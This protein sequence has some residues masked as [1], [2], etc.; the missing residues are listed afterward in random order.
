MQKSWS[1]KISAR[2]VS[3]LKVGDEVIIA[4][5]LWKLATVKIV[6]VDFIIADGMKF[7]RD[8]GFQTTGVG[9][10]GSKRR[11]LKATPERILLIKTDDMVSE[12]QDFHEWPYAT[13]EE[14]E[15]IFAIV[16]KVKKRSLQRR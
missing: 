16:E 10:G 11:L 8:T 6:T 4:G 3:D 9:F 15:T 5:W 2:W 13:P 14:V 12:I 7:H 1:D